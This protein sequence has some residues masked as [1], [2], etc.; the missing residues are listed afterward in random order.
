MAAGTSTLAGGA[1]GN[2]VVALSGAFAGG[3]SLVGLEVGL[4]PAACRRWPGEAHRSQPAERGRRG[5]PSRDHAS[6]PQDS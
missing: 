3:R 1:V 5:R 2:V 4:S 6:M